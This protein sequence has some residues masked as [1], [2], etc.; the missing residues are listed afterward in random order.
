M[1]C[2]AIL[3]AGVF[4]RIAGFDTHV[5]YIDELICLTGGDWN[6]SGKESSYRYRSSWDFARQMATSDGVSYAPLQF[7]LTY[8]FVKPY[9]P[10]LSP[11][12]LAASRI[13]SVIVGCLSIAL[14]FLL[15][16][17]LSGGRLCYSF[18]LPLTLLA[19]SRI[20]IVN[21]QQNHTYSIG[22]LAVI[23][24]M[25]ALVWIYD[26]KRPAVWT[27]TG[28]LFCIL[29]FANYQAVP[30]IILAISLVIC[31]MYLQVAID[32]AGRA[33]ASLRTLLLMPGLG[34]SIVFALWVMAHKAGGSIPWWTDDYSF[35]LSGEGFFG[36]LFGL[37]KNIYFVLESILLSGE[38]RLLNLLGFAAAMLAVAGGCVLVY[39]RRKLQINILP[40]LL[41][42]AASGLFIFLYF[43]G[44]IALSP[45]RHTMILTPAVLV[46]VFYSSRLLED[47]IAP[48]KT[49]WA[50]YRYTAVGLSILLLFGAILQYPEFYRRKTEVFRPEKVIE[51]SEK[52]GLR[53]VMTDWYNYNK[54]YMYLAKDIAEHRIELRTV[55]EEVEFPNEPFLLVGQSVDAFYMTYDPKNYEFGSVSR[56][57]YEHSPG[58]DFE[59]SPRINYYWPNRILIYRVDPPPGGKPPQPE[60]GWGHTDAPADGVFFLQNAWHRSQYLNV[61]NG[62]QSSPVDKA[63]ASAQWRLVKVADSP[64]AHYIIQNH[65]TGE[66]LYIDAETSNTLQTGTAAAPFGREYWVF[67]PVEGIP[68]EYR[69]RN[70][71]IPELY[72]NI[73]NQVGEDSSHREYKVQASVQENYWISSRWRLCDD[74][75]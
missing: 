15:F 52:E 39:R 21:S 50:V 74:K 5:T 3:A 12:A 41:S 65:G 46:V 18:L 55:D 1:L 17:L 28:I 33:A 29:P 51:F 6:S 59:P 30:I 67:E 75:P 44:K 9:Q 31:M 68:E 7:L 40:L 8:Y 43:T 58:Y 27:G 61:E 57:L 38:S 45:S 16:Y 2:G 42:F 4:F 35:A 71:Y 54:L 49:A 10:L 64:V 72:I 11:E 24:A 32:G 36:K 53:L 73:E 48:H 37:V 56:L 14:L 47:F 23:A 69:I 34:I 19:V 26:S 70:L 60:C 13:P 66:Y 62:L 25:L 63:W 22:V 20:N